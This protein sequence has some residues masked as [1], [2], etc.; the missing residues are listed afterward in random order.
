MSIES[1]L[2]EIV[3]KNQQ[4]HPISSRQSEPSVVNSAAENAKSVASFTPSVDFAA[5]RAQEKA[6]QEYQNQSFLSK[7]F[8]NLKTVS[9]AERE[10][11]QKNDDFGF[12]NEVGV[13]FIAARKEQS[14]QKSGVADPPKPVQTSVGSVYPKSGSQIT[15]EDAQ[16]AYD[17]E[18]K[19]NDALN[20][21][22]SLMKQDLGDFW[23]QAYRPE[24]VQKIKDDIL[25]SNKSLSEAE[26]TLRNLQ[27]DAMSARDSEKFENGMAQINA[28]S[29]EDRAALEDYV[30]SIDT[31]DNTF[32]IGN[33][34]RYIF[35]TNK[36]SDQHKALAEKY[37]EDRLK[38]LKAVYSRY[39]HEQDAKQAQ[40]DISE[41]VQDSNVSA[42]GHNV[43]GVG[44][45]AIGGTCRARSATAS[46]PAIRAV[47][48]AAASTSHNT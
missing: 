3:K 29:E 45:R 47:I 10:E 28:M 18:K 46:F 36:V 19:K 43:L 14:S 12:Y 40:S 7:F 20:E 33:P 22:L 4:E 35:S 9:A 23:E 38:E 13:P 8:S 21:K 27:S 39:L 6:R 5:L 17:E 31:R 2:L 48:A 26:K 25:Q 41:S 34:I 44:A 32:T 37:G 16:K 1:Q 11:E 30:R 24:E 15:I 42:I